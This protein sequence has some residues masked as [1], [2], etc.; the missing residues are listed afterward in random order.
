MEEVTLPVPF[1]VEST[2]A[3]LAV[4]QR[5]GG[6]RGHP[7]GHPVSAYAKNFGIFDALPPS[8]LYTQIA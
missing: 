6:V 8:P 4:G 2:V 3:D 5:E 7:W 1:L